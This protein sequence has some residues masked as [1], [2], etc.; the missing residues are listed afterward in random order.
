MPRIFLA[1]ICGIGVLCAAT[2][3]YASPI[4][5]AASSD[6]TRLYVLCEGNDELAVI[7][8]RSG[9][10][11]GRVQVGRVPKGLS[12]SGN[13]AY[14]ANSWSDTVSVIDTAS[15]QVTRTLKAGFEPNAVFATRSEL[16]TANRIGNDVSV[17]DLA[18]GA[19]TGRLT[20]GRG[21][22]YL[23]PS[24]DGQSIYCT[25][26]YPNIGRHR[27]PPES[28]ITVIDA[29]RQIVRERR[30]IDNVAGVFHVAFSNDGR[31]GIACQLRPKNLVPLAHVEH[32]WVFGD[33]LTLFGTDVG[34]PVQV[35]IDEL[36][37]YYTMPFGVVIAADKSTA[38]ISTTG[39][40]SVTVIDIKRLLDFV[41]AASPQARQA[42]ANDLSASAHFVA[43]R[44]PVGRA[45]KG[46][47]LS[48]DG[49]SLYVANRL[50]DTVSVIDTATRKVTRT[51]ALG[52]PA[53]L[54]P[55]RRGEQ[56]FFDARFAFHNGFSCA[57][58]HIESTF[59]GLQWDLEPDGF[60]KDIVDNRLLEDVDGTEPFKWNG[61]NPDL[62]TE[63]GPRT[64]KF[65]Y[66][67]QSF[68][69]PELSDV[70]A[71]V[72]SIPLRPNRFRLANGELTAAQ[73]RGKDI[74]E[75]TR[76]K[77]GTPIPETNQCGF[78][79]AGRHY[80]NQTQVD[81]GSGKWSD[82]SPV[83]DVPQLT[84]IALTAP[85]LH[86]GSARTLE[87]IWTVFN[88][89]DTHGV[90]NDLNKDE[91]NDLIEYLKTL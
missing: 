47:A 22:S 91:L 33:S 24:P 43:A 28:E 84:N 2:P 25:H 7:D 68:S 83:I 34:E 12:L 77:N 11:V 55:Q 78:C 71:Y 37:R 76:R 51:I 10:V 13:T 79:H 86:D 73:E 20:A 62:E 64:E 38:Y 72:K 56:L 50:D 29:V 45:P 30:P 88:P 39:A 60:G 69:P 87:E 59:D 46:I 23:T 80:T 67:S 6:G 27:T 36:E 82:R 18:T 44:I 17:I 19:E 31:L 8:A 52:G 61:G 75:R 57:N 66:R 81:V 53:E 63:C 58:C 41:R 70:V 40:N 16:Y 21:A 14:V 54:T 90:T 9:E 15:L 89:K 48:P 32:G 4:E 85:Y 35:L 49:A 26:I 5:L 65:F 74:F 3:R 42:L 1:L